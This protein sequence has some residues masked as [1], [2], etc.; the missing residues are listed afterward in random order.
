MNRNKWFW[1]S[2]IGLVVLLAISLSACSS[3]NK[4]KEMVAPDFTLQTTNGETITLS[5]LRGQPVMLTF[6]S[7]N[8]SSCRYQEPFLQAFYANQKNKS[9]K[10]ITVN[11]GDHPIVLEQHIASDNITFPVLLDTSRKVARS[12]GIPGVPVTVFIDAR[13]YVTAYK[14]GPFQSYED[15]EK[16]VDSIWAVLTRTS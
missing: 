7:I 11:I 6:W 15:I 1:I 14:I 16:A 9:L 4:A 12:Y 2:I 3:N 5:K 10:L 13:G 8:C